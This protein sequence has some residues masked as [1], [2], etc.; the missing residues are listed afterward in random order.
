MMR[1]VL[2]LVLRLNICSAITAVAVYCDEIG[3]ATD[4]AMRLL[5]L[6]IMMR[7]VLRSARYIANTDVAVYCDVM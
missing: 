1:L 3:I 4:Y 6:F 7:L 5:L 2:R